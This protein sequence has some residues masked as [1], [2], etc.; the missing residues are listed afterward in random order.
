MYLNN[1]KPEGLPLQPETTQMQNPTLGITFRETMAGG[2]TLGETDPN[3]GG[4]KGKSS[5]NILAMHSTI[6]IQDLDR[7]ISDPDHT[8]QIDGSIDYGAFGQN[9]PASTGVFNLFSPTDQ[10]GLKLMVYEM[11]FTAGGKN[12]Y[13]AGK[14]EVRDDSVVHMWAETT[15]LYTQ[16][17]EGSS[18]AGA[19]VGAGILT[20]GPLDL[21][22]MISTMRALN[23]SSTAEGAQAVMK[24]GEFFLGKLWDSYF[25][26][27]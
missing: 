23:A 12:Y 18:K 27:T 26:K 14:K 9:V 5:G 22:K 21:M 8:G 15:T 3:V 24:F 25:K 4:E 11:G 7:F 13:L 1:K 10:P 17:H 16:L 20:L 6:T 19:V 2:F